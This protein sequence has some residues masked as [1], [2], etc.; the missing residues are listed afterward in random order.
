M[1]KSKTVDDVIQNRIIGHDNIDPSKLQA[2]PNNWRT[3]PQNQ[4]DVIAGSLGEV[5]WVQ[6]VI[7]NKGTGLIVDGHARVEMALAMGAKSIP[8]AYVEL[9]PEEEATV[10]ATYDPIGAMARSDDEKL[11]AL[12]QQAG[13]Q[14]PALS[15]MLD[16]MM[17]NLNARVNERPFGGDNMDDIEKETSPTKTDEGY[18]AFEIVMQHDNKLKLLE[19]IRKIK[20]EHSLESN[21]D[22]LMVMVCEFL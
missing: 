11:K 1:S 19:A 3:H 17:S 20:M 18:S 15:A 9:T 4:M 13:P 6:S 7:V 22:A 21:E 5:G 10:L 2:N 12:L 14:D 16:E 8:V